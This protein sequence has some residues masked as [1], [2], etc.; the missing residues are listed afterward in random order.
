MTDANRL[1]V[2]WEGGGA[3]VVLAL[4]GENVK[5]SSDRPFAP[6]SRPSGTLAGG[7]ALRMKVHRSKKTS[8]APPTWVV[9]GRLLA[10]RR[11]FLTELKSRIDGAGAAQPS[12]GEPN[13]GDPSASAS[14]AADGPID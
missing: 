1:D 5:L 12:A 4:D 2:A 14:T 3:A 9:D 13:A 10:A 8:E 7:L 6:G 11:D